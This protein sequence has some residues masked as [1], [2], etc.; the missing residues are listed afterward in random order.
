MDAR[1]TK[2]KA[3]E[4]LGGKRFKVHCY[5]LTLFGV[6]GTKINWQKFEKLL[7]KSEK[8]VKTWDIPERASHPVAVLYQGNWKLFGKV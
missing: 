3:I 6:H 5:D 7:D 2:E 1:L 4:I 8:I